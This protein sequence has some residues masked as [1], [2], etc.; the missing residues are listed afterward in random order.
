MNRTPEITERS[1]NLGT[2]K[3]A[4]IERS[5]EPQ[6]VQYGF[7]MDPYHSSLLPSDELQ[8]NRKVRIVRVMCMGAFY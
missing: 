4:V 2:S 3:V 1:V 5:P 8:L 7:L 6:L